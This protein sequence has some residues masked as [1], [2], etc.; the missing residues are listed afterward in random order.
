MKETFVA[1]VTISQDGRTV[2]EHGTVRTTVDNARPTV[3]KAKSNLQW[4][5]VNYRNKDSVWRGGEIEFHS[6][7][8]EDGREPHA[9]QPLYKILVDLLIQH[10]VF[11]LPSDAKDLIKEFHITRKNIFMLIDDIVE[12]YKEGK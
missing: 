9:V 6:C 4:R 3:E 8:T 10:E 7:K 2:L 5:L 12:L 11:I 1:V